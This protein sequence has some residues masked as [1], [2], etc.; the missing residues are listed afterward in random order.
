MELINKHILITG[1]SSGIGRSTALIA[2]AKGA[3]VT[4]VARRESELKSLM[5]ELVLINKLSHSYIVLDLTDNEAID[6]KISKIDPIDG[7]VHSA[8]IVFPL[9]I[10]FIRKKHIEKVWGINSIAPILFTAT[11]L[12]N[13]LINPNASIVFVSSIS[14]VHPYVGGALYSSSKSA[15]ESYSKNLALE[16][17]GS[18][19]RSNVVSPALV[20]TE[21][22]NQ[23][24][25]S[26]EAS[27]ISVYEKKYPFGFGE[28]EDVANAILFFLSDSSK[29]ITGQNLVLDGGLTLNS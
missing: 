15:I 13:K 6:S 25:E 10:K 18:K 27:K 2:A 23:T 28:P 17:S 9:P 12:T 11:L 3:R 21:I 7:L 8:G 20:K 22:F 5:Q 26:S 16:L 19:I 4:V 29:W 14:T 1:A 24:I